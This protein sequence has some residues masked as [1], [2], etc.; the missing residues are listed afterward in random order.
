MP[1]VTIF[2]LQT[3]SKDGYFEAKDHSTFFT[4]CMV[5]I[6]IVNSAF[7]IFLQSNYRRRKVDHMN[8][9]SD[10]E[11]KVVQDEESSEERKSSESSKD[12]E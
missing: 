11:R 6:C 5:Y 3:C 12:S 8:V 7:I 1:S 9:E 2:P 4:L 10:L